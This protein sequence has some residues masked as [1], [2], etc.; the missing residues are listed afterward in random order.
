[1]QTK[2]T[3]GVCVLVGLMYD[4]RCGVVALAHSPDGW[5]SQ[6]PGR[7][8]IHLPAVA[9]PQGRA[10]RLPRGVSAR[11]HAFKTLHLGCK[12]VPRVKTSF[13]ASS[14]SNSMQIDGFFWAVESS[15]S[16]RLLGGGIWIVVCVSGV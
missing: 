6:R 2:L 3:G 9:S 5:L 13:G 8:C 10:V 12:R 14:I 16:H 1:M 11:S 7:A 4:S 15:A